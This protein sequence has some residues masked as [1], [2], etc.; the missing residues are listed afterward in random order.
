MVILEQKAAE[1][2]RE[3]LNANAKTVKVVAIRHVAQVAVIKSGL[4]AQVAVDARFTFARPGI[5]VQNFFKLGRVV[6]ECSSKTEF[7][8]GWPENGVA[9]VVNKFGCDYLRN[10]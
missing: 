10:Q 3:R 4:N 2:T 1:V 8:I 6:V 9:L 5:D 7:M